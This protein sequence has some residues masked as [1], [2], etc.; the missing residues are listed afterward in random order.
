MEKV[1][2]LL[3][4]DCSTE[5]TIRGDPRDGS[6]NVSRLLEE[7]LTAGKDEAYRH[8][9]ITFTYSFLAWDKFPKIH[10]GGFNYRYEPAAEIYEFI[11]QAHGFLIAAPPAWFGPN[12]NSVN[13]MAYM[14]VYDNKPAIAG[15][16]F[17]AFTH[18]PEDG[19]TAATMYIVGAMNNMGAKLPRNGKSFQNPYV[20]HGGEDHRQLTEHKLAA[21]NVVRTI[22]ESR[23]AAEAGFETEWGLREGDLVLQK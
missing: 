11:E 15:K 21:R 23:Y 6:G 12:V 22:I 13:L 16:P 3:G 18:V 2:T 8:G 5:D 7:A 20:T 1:I 10:P 19:G 4:M 14:S 9:F 17:C